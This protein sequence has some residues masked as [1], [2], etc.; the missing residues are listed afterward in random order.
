MLVQLD[1]VLDRGVL[2]VAPTAAGRGWDTDWLRR[3][4][5]AP[6]GRRRGPR[7]RWCPTF[8]AALWRRC[9]AAPRR[10]W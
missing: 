1:R 8:E 10:C 5:S 9:S 7:G 3:W 4:L 6:R 2:T